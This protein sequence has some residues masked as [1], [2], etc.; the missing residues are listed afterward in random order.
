MQPDRRVAATQKRAMLQLR[1]QRQACSIQARRIAG[2][3]CENGIGSVRVPPGQIVPLLGSKLAQPAID[4]R[5]AWPQIAGATISSFEATEQ[6]TALLR[7][8]LAR[9][10]DADDRVVVVFHTHE[11]ALRLGAGELIAHM[12]V[13]LSA[14][15]EFWLVAAAGGPW[16]IDYCSRDNEV[17][18]SATMDPAHESM[19][20]ANAVNEPDRPA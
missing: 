5:F 3:L 6:A 8:A 17:C 18:W 4:E 7:K 15:W 10:T 1:Q 16:L 12:P 19:H 20:S 11:S 2:L 14:T 9:F 13:I